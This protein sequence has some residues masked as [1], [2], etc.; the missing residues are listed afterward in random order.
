MDLFYKFFLKTFHTSF[1]KLFWFSQWNFIHKFEPK[2]HVEHWSQ[3]NSQFVI[4][5]Q[6]IHQILIIP[7]QRI[8]QNL[9]SNWS[10]NCLSSSPLSPQ[11]ENH[12]TDIIKHVFKS[13]Y[14]TR[15]ICIFRTFFVAFWVR[16]YSGAV[17]V[18]AIYVRDVRF[19]RDEPNR[20][21]IRA[22]KKS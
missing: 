19:I 9:D 11:I 17:Y 13:V 18:R 14:V 7:L 1:D 4:R 15:S 21:E 12:K 22:I 10:W 8:Q 5:K 20:V 6:R 16:I 3:H 2:L